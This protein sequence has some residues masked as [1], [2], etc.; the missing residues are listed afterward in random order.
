[1][2]P[3]V[4]YAPAAAPAPAPAPAPAAHH[5]SH[6]GF[7]IV[8]VL[9]VLFAIA[10]GVYEWQQQQQ[11]AS[12]PPPSPTP[13]TVVAP[14]K[15]PPKPPSPK[16]LT[17]AQIVHRGRVLADCKERQYAN[18][19]CGY[20]MA[21]DKWFLNCDSPFFGGNCTDKCPQDDPDLP[22]DYTPGGD[23]KRSKTPATCKCP[24]ANRFANRNIVGGC[25]AGKNDGDTGNCEKGYYGRLCDKKGTYQ[26]CVHGTQIGE[27]CYCRTG[28]GGERC[29]HSVAACRTKDPGA[30][31]N[32]TL[33]DGS[34]VCTT[35]YVSAPGAAGPNAKCDQCDASLGYHAKGGRCVAGT[36]CE[37]VVVGAGGTTS[38]PLRSAPGKATTF[39]MA[40]YG[41][42]TVEYVQL[43]R[44][45][46]TAACTARLSAADC[47]ILVTLP[48]GKNE[49]TSM[50]L[51]AAGDAT[52]RGR[53]VTSITLGAD[54][55]VQAGGGRAACAGTPFASSDAANCPSQSGNVCGY[56]WTSA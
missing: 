25:R 4:R 17:H 24:E 21:A 42:T 9:V 53:A 47:D 10:Y 18:T 30:T 45:A 13:P 14:A 2:A 37:L 26:G 16:P 31:L 54:A 6:T 46:G 3:A 48:I 5:S 12:S 40:A 39:Q 19:T 23:L 35:G 1:M 36:V 34:C 52:K 7:L 28:Y 43:K 15:P 22:R 8:A 20:D 11:A 29:E 55:D 33:N 50:P 44:V 51:T 38:P 56:Y 32:T 41:T 49:L 27:T